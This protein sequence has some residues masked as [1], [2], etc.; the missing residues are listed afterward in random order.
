MGMWR[1]FQESPG[2]LVSTS[3]IQPQKKDLQ[4]ACYALGVSS[5][6]SIADMLNRLQELLNFK[7]IY[8]KL[9]LKLQKAGEKCVEADA[10]LT[11]GEIKTE[12]LIQRLEKILSVPGTV[13]E[14]QLFMTE[15]I[16]PEVLIQWLQS[17][18]MCRYRAESVLLK[19][20]SFPGM[21]REAVSS[22]ARKSKPDKDLQL[23]EG[24]G[25]SGE[26]RTETNRKEGVKEKEEKAKERLRDFHKSGTA[27]YARMMSTMSESAQNADCLKKMDIG[28]MAAQRNTKKTSRIQRRRTESRRGK[29]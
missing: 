3:D 21:K 2:T 22:K 23:H 12:D 6:G 18:N 20:T 5:E 11:D 14:K 13:A 26:Q 4:D 10:I 1:I 15:V 25:R 19:C 24:C 27:G 29:E 8:P 16:L 9:F 28:L 7:D 17:Q